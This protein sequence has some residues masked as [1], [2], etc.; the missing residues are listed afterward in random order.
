MSSQQKEKQ[1][2]DEETR[3]NAS[4][5]GQVQTEDENWDDVPTKT[6]RKTSDEDLEEELSKSEDDEDLTDEDDEDD[7]DLTEEGDMDDDEDFAEE[8]K[9]VSQ[10]IENRPVTNV[11]TDEAIRQMEALQGN[12]P[13]LEAALNQKLSE[14]S[15][16]RKQLD[17]EESDLK[18]RIN[19]LRVLGGKPPL[20]SVE[21]VTRPRRGRKPRAL[22]ADAVPTT[23]ELNE[24]GEPLPRGK[25]G[26]GKRFRNEQTLKQ[27]IVKVLMRMSHPTTGKPYTGFV[28]DISNKVVQE[29]N[30]KTTSSK[31]T[32]TV[33]IQLYRLEEEGKV[34]HNDDKSYTLRKQVVREMGGDPDKKAPQANN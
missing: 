6:S 10:E 34:I 11:N 21:E 1:K 17:N 3:L 32:N 33:R 24:D 18:S 12:L 26:R 29:E 2:R 19:F 14:I 13:A 20:E 15:G 5:L 9:V 8:K 23:P 30:Y 31:R 27:A 28:N 16:K 4:H 7:E 25:G 22:T